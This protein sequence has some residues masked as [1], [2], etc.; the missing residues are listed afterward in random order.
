LLPLVRRGGRRGLL[1]WDAASGHRANATKA[2]IRRLR[3]DTV[4]I[5]SGMTWLL[6]GIDTVVNRPFKVYL[7]R[8]INDYFAGGV[9]RNARGN[10]IKPI[11]EQVIDWVKAAWAHITPEI[12]ESALKHYYLHP[13]AGWA[14]TKAAGHETFG[15]LIEDEL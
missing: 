1:I 3:I 6:Q 15:N 8:A 4:M 13:T 10:P 7:R 5:P 2:Y 14:D 12:I 11:L 9:P